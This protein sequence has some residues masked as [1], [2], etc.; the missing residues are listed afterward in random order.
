[1]QATPKHITLEV[2]SV[3]TSP[4]PKWTEASEQAQENACEIWV[5]TNEYIEKWFPRTSRTKCQLVLIKKNSVSACQLK[6]HSGASL[7]KQLPLTW[8]SLKN[9]C[10][11]KLKL[12][13]TASKYWPSWNEIIRMSSSPLHHGI[14]IAVH[15]LP[16]INELNQRTHCQYYH[17]T[18]EPECHPWLDLLC[19]ICATQRKLSLV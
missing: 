16:R 11:S 17:G 4:L 13:R 12:D 10:Q 14:A 9:K 15:S 5:I 19:H 6:Q 18:W 7:L 3:K 1:M 2:I 8:V